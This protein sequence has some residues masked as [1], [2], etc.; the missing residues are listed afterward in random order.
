MKKIIY[1]CTIVFSLIACDKV[2]I[3]EELDGM[4]RLETVTYPDSIVYPK[5]IFYSFQ[6]HLTQVS[7]H[8]DTGLPK[9][10][11][12]NLDYR[13]NT[14]SMSGF[15]TFPMESYP[16]TAEMLREF[17]IYNDSTVFKILVLEEEKLIMENEERI[18]ALRKW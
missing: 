18:Y 9:R 3:N 8:Y 5:Q 11:L 10:F 2:Y 14:L 6:R 16:A 12:G 4:W 7:K 13:G 15:Y 17:H 1:I